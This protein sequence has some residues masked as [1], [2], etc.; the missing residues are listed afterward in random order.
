MNQL[1][2]NKKTPNTF[3]NARD[4]KKNSVGNWVTI[5]HVQPIKSGSIIN[6]KT[7]ARDSLSVAGMYVDTAA[8][9]N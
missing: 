2:H 3:S 8:R 6:L 1:C 9:W 5:R 4:V 7:L